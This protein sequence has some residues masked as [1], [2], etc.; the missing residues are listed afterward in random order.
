[1]DSFGHTLDLLLLIMDEATPAFDSETEKTIQDNIDALKGQHTIL[2]VAH[3]LSTIK[4]AD[5]IILM[6]NGEIE[7]IGTYQQLTK[8]APMFKRMVAL[9]EL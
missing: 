7:Q 5:R 4:N 2:I 8:N 3:R 1:M 6:S 9:Q